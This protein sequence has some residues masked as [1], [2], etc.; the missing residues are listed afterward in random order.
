MEKLEGAILKLYVY[1]YFCTLWRHKL[2]FL[3]SV[4]FDAYLMRNLSKKKVC[5]DFFRLFDIFATKVYDCDICIHFVKM[6][7]Y[8]LTLD[9]N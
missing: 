4:S 9:T 3:L 2:F 8:L 1:T 5:M 7:L 6:R